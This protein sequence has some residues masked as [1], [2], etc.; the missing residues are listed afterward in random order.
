LGFL[1]GKGEGTQVNLYIGEVS[2]GEVAVTSEVVEVGLDLDPGIAG[3]VATADEEGAAD[4]VLRA[5]LGAVELR[6]T[7]RMHVDRVSGAGTTQIG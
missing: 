2:A 3:L 6:T 4:R 1:E 7:A 5:G